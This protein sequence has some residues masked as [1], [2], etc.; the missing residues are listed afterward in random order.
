MRGTKVSRESKSSRAQIH[1]NDR[2]A[3]SQ[4]CALRH[5]KPDAAGADND[6]AVASLSASRVLNCTDT[7]YYCTSNRREHGKRNVWRN[8]DR[9]LFRD[10][11]II[12]EACRAIEMSYVLVTCSESTAA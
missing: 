6:D 10:D 4:R 12:S 1:R 9:A 7:G 8:H 5:V 2:I 3:L 11:S